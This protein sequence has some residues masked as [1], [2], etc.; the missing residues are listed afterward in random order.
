MK[1]NKYRLSPSKIDGFR[2]FAEGRFNKTKEQYIEELTQGVK[3][4]PAMQFGTAV[5][6]FIET[7]KTS[8][9]MPEEVAYLT[10][11]R[12]QWEDKTKEEWIEFDLF[13]GCGILGRVDMI[14]G[15]M[16]E[17]L[18]VSGRFWGVDFYEKSVQWKIYLMGLSLPM[19][20]YHIFQKR[21]TKRPHKFY[22]HSFDLYAYTGMDKEVIR[23]AERMIQ[24]CEWNGIEK[25]IID[26]KTK[27]NKNEKR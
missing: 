5:H 9:L 3:E 27:T 23:W 4:T 16:V 15:V 1:K 18:K 17:D 24:F 19:F 2:L 14:D 25:H 8:D 11:F 10:P 7:G 13:P 21:G 20:R 22:Y 26:K 12:H 6:D